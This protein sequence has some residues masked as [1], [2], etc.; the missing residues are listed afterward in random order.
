ML[1][2]P[3]APNE[4]LLNPAIGRC[5][6]L[7]PIAQS[8]SGSRSGACRAPVDSDGR[9]R[10]LCG[11]AFACGICPRA[12]PARA[13]VTALPAVGCVK[14]TSKCELPPKKRKTGKTTTSSQR[15]SK[16]CVSTAHGSSRFRPYHCPRSQQV[17]LSAGQ[18]CALYSP[19]LYKASLACVLQSIP[20]ARSNGE[21]SSFLA[22]GPCK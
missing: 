1:D 16:P 3:S 6:F 14:K 12:G 18:P 11:S 4:I 15:A 17:G 9:A 2:S 22:V 10:K 21:S 8:T 5:H 7:P 20:A 13:H 19:I